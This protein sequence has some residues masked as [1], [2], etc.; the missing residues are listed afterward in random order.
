MPPPIPVELLPY[1][2]QWLDAAE[3][4]SQRLIEG[5]GGRIATVHHVGSTSIPGIRAKP[6]LDLIPVINELPLF[7][8][9]RP[10]VEAL[11][12]AWHGEYGL[13][14]R[15]YCTF[16]EPISGRRR[17]QLHCYQAGSREII[18]LLAFRD[19]LR[20]HPSVARD[21]E[22]VKTRCRDQHPSDS[23]AYTACK[24]DWIAEA[25]NM[26]GLA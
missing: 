1:D 21:Y 2:P 24:S 9:A 18:R 6:V 15:R 17:V 8:E 3:L 10:V 16:D 4:E 14:G 11:G 13:P 19:Y 12:Y 7:D 20:R 23:H 25:L 5:L 26:L 22:R